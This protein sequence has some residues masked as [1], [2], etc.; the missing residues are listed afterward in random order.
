MP[1]I[2]KIRVH[3]IEYDISDPN[4][5]PKNE[6]LGVA[7]GGTGATAP[8]QARTNLGL[9]YGNTAGT[10]CQGNDPRLSDSRTPTGHA[11]PNNSYGVGSASNY[12]HVK[13]SDAVNSNS[14][15]TS[16]VSATPKA[17]KEAYDLASSKS[18]PLSRQSGNTTVYVDGL[19][20]T[21]SISFHKDGYTALMYSV[22]CTNAGSVLNNV[23]DV[24][25]GNENATI[26]GRISNV[27]VWSDPDHPAVGNTTITV[28]I[29][30]VK[31]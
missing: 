25:L 17:V 22:R 3:G 18:N 13:L 12:G 14:D 31:N 1:S 15:A 26:S 9:S 23:D 2:E 28:D 21:W 11:S 19:N 27:G 5:L 6:T 4:K 10:V 16:G 7:N 24:T 20:H 8:A 29:L 30:W